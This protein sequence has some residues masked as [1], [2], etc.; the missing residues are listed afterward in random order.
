[1]KKK[2]FIMV[3]LVTFSV[4]FA[5]C[6]PSKT[7]IA[8]T[9]VTPSKTES[10]LTKMTAEQILQTYVDAGFPI[11]NV[12]VY[13]AEND[14][15]RMLGSPN[16][17]TSKAT[18]ADTRVKET[19]SSTL[20]NGTVEVFNNAEDAQ[21]FYDNV[22][23]TPILPDTFFQYNYIFENVLMRLEGDLT[24]AQ[25]KQYEDAFKLLGENKS[26]PKFSE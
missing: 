5:G 25:A 1:M 7:E 9:N 3:L 6:S 13:T 11:N 16:S 14:A 18:F 2:L 24:P 12:I 20:V 26:L 17:Y 4:L 10:A 22:T 23:A 8:P 21:T 15:T 19:Y